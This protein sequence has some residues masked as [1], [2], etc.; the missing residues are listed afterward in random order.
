MSPQLTRAYLLLEQSRFT[1]AER[2]FRAALSAEPDDAF[3][4]VGLALALGGQDKYAEALVS[5]KHAI[6]LAPTE[7]MPYY[8]L[9]LTQFQLDEPREALKAIREAIR[10]E[11]DDAS[12]HAVLATIHHSQER[13]HEALDAADRGL[14]EDPAHP[15]CLNIRAAALT[16]LQRHDEATK[17]I[18]HALSEHP[19]DAHTHYV[20]G[21]NLMHRGEHPRAIEHFREALRA[22]PTLDQARAG[23]VECLK[24]R[25]FLYRQLLAFFL[26]MS[27]KGGTFRNVLIFGAFFFFRGLRAFAEEYPAIKPVVIPLLVVYTLFVLLTWTGD[28]IFNLLLRLD[29]DG[30]IALNRREIRA[31]NWIGGL[32]S[33]VA[34]SILLGFVTGQNLLFFVALGLYFLI[35][36]MVVLFRASEGWPRRFMTYYL[37]GMVLVGAIGTGLG[38]WSAMQP[39][40]SPLNSGIKKAFMLCGILYL[41]ASILASWVGNIIAT[42][43]PNRSFWNFWRTKRGLGVAAFAL[44]I[45]VL[46]LYLIWAD[47][48][49]DAK[50]SERV[51]RHRAAGD[52]IAVEDFLSADRSDP[53]SDHGAAIIA[54]LAARLAGIQAEPA[55]SVLA[56][57]ASIALTGAFEPLPQRSEEPSRTF[58]AKHRDVVDQL[59]ALPESA[60][61]RLPSYV[62]VAL[63]AFDIKPPSPLAPW[64]TA[65]RLLS[66]EAWMGLLDQEPQRAQTAVL[67]QLRLAA[68]LDGQAELIT[69][70][71]RSAIEANACFALELLLSR[72]EVDREILGD[73]A[74][75][76]DLRIGGPPIRRSVAYERARF[77]KYLEDWKTEKAPPLGDESAVGRRP[78]TNSRLRELQGRLVDEHAALIIASE[79]VDNLR[80]F[81]AQLQNPNAD[82]ETKARNARV[83]S[84]AP[85]TYRA[86][87]LYYDRVA[88][89]RSARA[90]I[91]AELYRMDHGAFP[92]SWNDLSPSYIPSPSV[93]PY[94]DAALILEMTPSELSIRSVGRGSDLDRYADSVGARK[95][96]EPVE[97]RLVTPERRAELANPAKS[98]NSDRD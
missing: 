94:S 27:R 6:H 90:G 80:R 97:M 92:K 43:N 21:L 10:I 35:F 50:W 73:T 75:A 44:I 9:A 19:E 83:A 34:V 55:T 82:E 60:P 37:F 95:R 81:L 41:G 49:A 38:T 61:H 84:M 64:L 30:R 16:A 46:P 28:P 79:S 3:I 18:Q 23:I 40:S 2:A 77:V 14:S 48:R 31:S 76:L 86:V 36:P 59:L 91:A 58:L 52:P 13:H 33:G 63:D 47:D 68:T 62:A 56:F 32:L 93:D 69:V 17:T 24:A 4:H 29:K 8:A 42:A 74:T 78:R 70:A 11:P 25:N 98:S 85:S 5:A 12:F 65:S 67:A 72:G 51:A 20:T 7:S 89:L 96:V 66:L 53:P 45:V 88:M 15:Q 71:T 1:D 57:D 26:W 54:R 87:A 39:A 22:D